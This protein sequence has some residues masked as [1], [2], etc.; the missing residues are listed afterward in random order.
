MECLVQH[1]VDYKGMPADRTE[2]GG[3]ISAALIAVIQLCE[4][5]S[6]I[7]I[8]VN[9]VPYLIGTLHLSS[10]V[11]ANTVSNFLGALFSL[12]SLGG[13][14]AESYLGRYKTI[15]I[16]ALIQGLGTCFLSI[17]TALPQLWPPPCDLEADSS[18][19]CEQASRLQMAAMYSSL[20]L[21]AVGTGGLLPN[22]CVFISD[23]FDQKNDKEK[24]HLRQFFN[25]LFCLFAVVALL[26][27]T[28]LVYIQ[29]E[30]QRSWGYGVCSLSMLLAIFMFLAGTRSYRY[31]KLTRSA[32]VPILQVL[33]AAIKKR[34]YQ[35]P[36][37]IE[38]LY[39]DNPES[40]RIP[41]TRHFKFLDKAAIPTKDAFVSST[42]SSVPDPWK[43]SSVTRVEEV[44]MIAHL[45]PFWAT[46]IL[47]WTA[48]SQLMT[49][50]VEQ[51]STMNRSIG[52][53]FIVP[54]GSVA[55]F[56]VLPIFITLGLY[57]P[58]IKPI[59]RKLRGKPGLT[60]LQKIGIG[61]LLAALGMAAAAVIESKRLLVMRASS[62]SSSSSSSSSPLPITVL[63]LIPQFVLVGS[64]AGFMYSGQFNLF[65]KQHTRK[66]MKAIGTCIFLTTP[67]LGF[68]L[69]SFLVSLVQR[70]STIRG[71]KGWI[72]H[73]IN[74]GRIDCFYGLL[75][76]LT[77]ADFEIF[78][79][80]AAAFKPQQKTEMEGVGSGASGVD[81]D[82]KTSTTV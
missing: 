15:L 73:S 24:A 79:F 48:F 26:A 23:Q 76:A 47:F 78:L 33:L 5:F 82:V 58:V 49:F 2:T 40:S 50:S 27:V 59:W 35:V 30:Y 43:V 44:K 70:I 51:A 80:C 67:A 53:A 77:L 31:K 9:L 6:T 1:A 57:G 20:Y 63:F 41:H 4:G 13:I 21:M 34:K 75:A 74:N 29:D 42:N 18:A 22:I 16:F 69:S 71:G 64:G 66:G 62:P 52:G 3:W 8:C 46:T 56:F 68:F 10:Q 39:E 11:A 17:S 25:C 45:L 38:V 81:R 28:L 14:L 61:L 55:I 65:I 72:G 19:D 7:G 12:S 54:A 37:N 32:L 60:S 36:A